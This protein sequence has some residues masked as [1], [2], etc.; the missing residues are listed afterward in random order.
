MSDEKLFAVQFEFGKHVNTLINSKNVSHVEALG[1]L[2]M[3]KD[4]ILED[5]RKNTNNV[6]RVSGR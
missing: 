3:A 4:Q 5:L 1:L 2:E 6:V